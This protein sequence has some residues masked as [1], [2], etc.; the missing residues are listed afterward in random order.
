MTVFPTPMIAQLAQAMRTRY[1]SA[2]LEGLTDQAAFEEV[3]RTIL[4]TY[5]EAK[6]GQ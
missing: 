4:E 5:E 3:I 1:Y 2:K 6:N